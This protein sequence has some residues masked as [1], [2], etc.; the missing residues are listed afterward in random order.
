[1]DIFIKMQFCLLFTRNYYECRALI[2]AKIY[3]KRDV[4]GFDIVKFPFLDGDIT[5]ST[6]YGVNISQPI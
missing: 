2:S 6:Y 4:F 1:M 3:D 5:R